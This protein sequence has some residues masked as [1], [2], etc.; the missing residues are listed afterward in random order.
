MQTSCSEL[1]LARPCQVLNLRTSFRGRARNV[2]RRLKSWRVYI[3][4]L[5]VSK[6]AVMCDRRPHHVTSQ[7]THCR[8]GEIT[9]SMRETTGGKLKCVVAE[10]I[11][12]GIGASLVAATFRCEGGRCGRCQCAGGEFQYVDEFVCTHTRRLPAARD[13]VRVN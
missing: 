5:S 1:H 6:C 12:L 8:K 3:A 13:S 7:V 11:A 2:S 9:R 10:V 4:S